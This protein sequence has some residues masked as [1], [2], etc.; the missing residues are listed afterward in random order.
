MGLGLMTG[1]VGWGGRLVSLLLE[2]RM[3]GFTC[4]A[5]SRASY[6]NIIRSMNTVPYYR[7]GT[8]RAAVGFTSSR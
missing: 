7:L 1:T 8:V 3:E 4:T 5:V 6:R 2:T